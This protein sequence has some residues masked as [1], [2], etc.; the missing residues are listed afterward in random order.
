MLSTLG[1]ILYAPS[2][3]HIATRGMRYH[4]T[5]AAPAFSYYRCESGVGG[6]GTSGGILHQ[7]RYDAGADYNW[8]WAGSLA[9]R[10]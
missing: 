6:I 8:G 3:L 10:F 2:L 7:R 9:V 5:A 1:N 4:D